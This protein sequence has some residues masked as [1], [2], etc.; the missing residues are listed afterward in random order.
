MTTPYVDPQ[1]VHNPAT[2]T[3]PPASWGDTV[4]DNQQLFASPPMVKAVRNAQAIAHNTMTAISFT[5]PDEWDTDNFH[6]TVT[7]PTRL[8]IPTG[9]SGKYLIQ[10]N[11]GYANGPAGTRYIKIQK[12]GATALTVIQDDDAANIWYSNAMAMAHLTATDY[13][14]VIAYQ[15]STWALFAQTSISLTWMSL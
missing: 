3:S 9:L 1:T 6:S 8:T 14:E 4:R 2:G 12:N 13:V 11:L 5:D 10:V 15:Y 7:N